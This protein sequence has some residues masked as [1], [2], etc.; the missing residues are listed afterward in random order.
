MIKSPK[1][2]CKVAPMVVRKGNMKQCVVCKKLYVNLSDHILN[3]HKISRTD[4]N[5]EAYVHAP[6]VVPRCYT[7][8]SEGCRIMLEGSELEE[9][10]AE[11]SEEV[12]VQTDTL[13]SIKDLKLQME[14]LSCL[15]YT[16]PS[17]RDKRQSRMP[18]SA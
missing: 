9:A 11:Y 5:Y 14:V 2:S 4:P 3:K 7:K 6:P 10:K 1:K 15:L 16:S 13:K 18:S 8:V 12:E 17:P